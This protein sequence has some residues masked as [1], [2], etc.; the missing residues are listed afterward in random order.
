MIRT[1][2]ILS[3]ALMGLASAGDCT[4]Y[5]RVADSKCAE[6][7]LGSFVGICP[8]S[9][10]VSKGSLKKGTCSA[11]GYTVKGSDLKQKAG[12]C[13]TLDFVTYT[14]SSSTTAATSLASVAAPAACK[15]VT[16]Q[17]NFNLTEYVTG[18]KWFIHQ[19]MAISYLPVKRNFCV[20]ASYSF[21]SA[22]EVRVHNYANE[23]KVNGDVY[24][25]DDTLKAL[26]GICG[27]VKDKSNPQKL[28][29]GPCRLPSWIPGATGPYWIIAAGPSPDKY[30]WALVS[31]GQ[32]THE[33]GGGCSTGT[34]VNGSGLWIFTRS[35]KRDESVMDAVRAKAEAQGF[36][37]SVLND[38]AQ[39]GC[40][41][42][43]KDAP[44]Q[45]L[46]AGAA[47]A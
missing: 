8:V 6:T 4:S 22:T 41:Y 35:S 25:S 24:D 19:Q 32:P 45:M 33:S 46:R 39:E 40:T 3:A 12:P 42:H 38:V 13:G 21:N 30:E 10:V 47:L 29:V 44:K 27:S 17:A 11:L 31:G 7:C 34:G 37:L 20:T 18:G 1:S 14:K 16:T 15:P 36:D 5:T 2:I 28:S 26:G 9:L 43:P 23:D